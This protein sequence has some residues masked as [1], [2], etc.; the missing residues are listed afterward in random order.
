MLLF[1]SFPF[2]DVSL[3]FFSICFLMLLYHSIPSFSLCFSI[4]TIL[5]LCLSCSIILFHLFSYVSVS[6]FSICFL[7]F[8]YHSFPFVLTF[9]ISL[10]SIVFPPQITDA[11]L[12]TYLQCLI[13]FPFFTGKCWLVGWID[14]YIDP[15]NKFLVH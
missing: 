7:M 4:I 1:Q 2:L 13:A 11:C 3:S 6:F 8:L 12:L 14:G 9:L 10:V 5:Y 15:H